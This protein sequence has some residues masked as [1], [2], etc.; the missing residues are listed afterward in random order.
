[1]SSND[2]EPRPPRDAR[3]AWSRLARAGS[4]RPTRSNILA[5]LLAGAL[6]FAIIAQVRQTSIEGLENLREDELVRIFADVDQDG[7][8][9]AGEISN[10]RASLELLRSRT[11][12]EEEARRCRPALG[13]TGT[14]LGHH[15]VPSGD[16]RLLVGGGDHLAGAQRHQHRPE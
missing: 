14:G 12:S 8:Q 11:T 16:Q 2:V 5:A 3:H 7:D 6:G 15:Q 4:P 13:R 9:L 1:M 10:L